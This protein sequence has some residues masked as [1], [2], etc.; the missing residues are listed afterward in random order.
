MT[1]RGKSSGR[2]SRGSEKSAASPTTADG[3]DSLDRE[4]DTPVS[5]QADRAAPPSDDEIRERA[6]EF[7]LSRGRDPGTAHD[8]WVRAE[9][10][11]R[12]ERGEG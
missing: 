4:V 1:K 12:A 6:Y 10:A 11:L 2:S 3:G 8:D 9:R 5:R 7:Y